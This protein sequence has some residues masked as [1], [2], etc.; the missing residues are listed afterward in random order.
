MTTL[1]TARARWQ[2]GHRAAAVLS[3]VVLIASG[4][5]EKDLHIQ[6]D[7]WANPELA[8]QVSVP[9]SATEVSKGLGSGSQGYAYKVEFLIPNDQWRDYV[10]SYY[11]DGVQESRIARTNVGLVPWQCKQA[12]RDGTSF[13]GWVAEDQIPYFDSTDTATRHL[14]VLTDCQPGHTLV[15]WRLYDPNDTGS[16]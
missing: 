11:P 13:R 16:P 14:S 15:Q 10:Q 2:R 9:D 12:F 4:C 7:D 5:S 3:L 1:A 6:N 8:L